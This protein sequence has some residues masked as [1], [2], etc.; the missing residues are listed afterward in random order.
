MKELYTTS[1]YI[2]PN[3]FE[4]LFE[5]ALFYKLAV[6]DFKKS[7]IELENEVLDEDLQ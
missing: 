4:R 7:N 6:P 1:I 2:E 5:T 3:T